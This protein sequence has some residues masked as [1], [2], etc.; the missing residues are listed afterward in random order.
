VLANTARLVTIA[1]IA[2]G[3]KRDMSLPVQNSRSVNNS[4]IVRML[5]NEPAISVEPISKQ[6]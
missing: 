1:A 2:V 6:A 4:D 3:S 5:G